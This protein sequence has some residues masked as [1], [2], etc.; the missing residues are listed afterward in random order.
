MKIWVKDGSPDGMHVLLR[1]YL[2]TWD[3]LKDF[4][5]WVSLLESKEYKKILE[6]QRKDCKA[7]TK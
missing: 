4:I 2:M 7:K 3:D 5:D 1:T 6:E